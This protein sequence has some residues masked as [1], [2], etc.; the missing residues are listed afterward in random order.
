MFKLEFKFMFKF[1]LAAQKRTPASGAT[2]RVPKVKRQTVLFVNRAKEGKMPR[3][4]SLSCP[5]KKSNRNVV[6]TMSRGGSQLPETL[7][8]QI[9]QGRCHGHGRSSV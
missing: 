5:L 4:K 6:N 8:L 9:D 1:F 3:P 2:E 7:R